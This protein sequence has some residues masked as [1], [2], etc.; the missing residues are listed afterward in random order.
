MEED[1]F[2]TDA[3]LR[4]EGMALLD[5]RGLRRLIEEYA[6][7]HVFGSMTLGL[8]VWRDMDLAMEAPGLTVKQFFELGARI[9]DLLSPWKMFFT[10][11]QTHDGGQFPRGLYWGIRLGDIKEGAWKID[12]WAFDSVRCQV[13]AREC[14]ALKRRINQDN[15]HCI[16]SIKSQIW[17][18]PRYRDTVTSQDVYN[19]VLDHG[20]NTIDGFWEYMESK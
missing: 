20:I 12:L 7:V 17:R 8:M 5:G 15:R 10:D 18:D 1:L 4:A 19:A 11:N 14:E 2:Q 3:S 6:P 16:L 9:T 13:M